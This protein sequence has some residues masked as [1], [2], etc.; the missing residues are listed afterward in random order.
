M[1]K[2]IILVGLIALVGIGV[3][4]GY[5][6]KAVIG[7]KDEKIKPVAEF[8]QELWKNYENDQFSLLVPENWSEGPTKGSVMSND[9]KHQQIIYYVEKKEDIPN[10]AAQGFI[11]K[12]QLKEYALYQCRGLG[13]DP[14]TAKLSD[15]QDFNIPGIKGLRYAVTY[16][17]QSYTQRTEDILIFKDDIVYHFWIQQPANEPSLDPVAVE[18]FDKIMQT[19]HIK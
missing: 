14:C 1:R 16:E 9:D 13:D 17:T 11:E 8:S 18:K 2:I 10:K 7:L 15:F 12:G 19:L 4:I 5:K 3:L 6:Y